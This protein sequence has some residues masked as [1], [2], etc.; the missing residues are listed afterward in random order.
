MMEECL[1][2]KKAL[3][4]GRAGGEGVELMGWPGFLKVVLWSNA[5]CKGLYGRMGDLAP[6]DHKLLCEGAVAGL[7]QG[8][9]SIRMCLGTQFP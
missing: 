4:N 2:P 9:F 6:L 8:A 1:F 7:L 3:R 5:V